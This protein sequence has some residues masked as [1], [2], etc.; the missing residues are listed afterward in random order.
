MKVERW[1]KEL[2]PG[3]KETSPKLPSRKFR[4]TITRSMKRNKR[5]NG[6]KKPPVFVARAERAFS[7][8]ARK[9]RSENRRCELSPVVWP[10]VGPRDSLKGTRAMDV[11]MSERKR[12]REESRELPS[13]NSEK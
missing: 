11:F 3:T 12:E 4:P 9:L 10:N 2:I 5:S 7:R 8:V 13:K 6:A 1:M